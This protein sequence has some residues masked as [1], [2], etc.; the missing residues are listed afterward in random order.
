MESLNNL[1]VQLRD[2][3]EELEKIKSDLLSIYAKYN[4]NNIS[5]TDEELLKAAIQIRKF[6]DKLSNMVVYE[7]NIPRRLNNLELFVAMYDFVADRIYVDQDTSHDIIGTLITNKGVCQGYCQLMSFLC[8][9]FNIPYLY[10]RTETFDENNN[11]LGS[12]GNFEVIVQGNNGFSHCLHCDPTIDSPKSETDTLGFNS[13]LIQDNDIN[14][15]YHKQ[16]PSGNSISSFYNNFLSKQNFEQ[17]ISLLTQIT[18]VEQIISE[19]TDE[20]IINGHF[21]ILKNNLVELNRFFKLNINFNNLDN[22]QLIDVYRAMYKY[23]N[24][25]ATPF[26]PEEL[27]QAIKN[28]KA[29][30]IM[31]EQHIN[32]DD[33]LVQSEKIFEQRMAKSMEQHEKYWD[34]DGGISLMYMESKK[35]NG[36]TI[37]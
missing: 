6:V 31:Y 24:S 33:A 30:E 14:R 37:K 15:Y 13:L 19:K 16:I 8:E 17:S 28:V 18:P 36:P 4:G 22:S 12:H 35:E 27:T 7:N 5:Y 26:D 21:A 20:E 3:K 32:F 2:A 1:K 34:K 11:P 10:K 9:S 25:I 23:Y 29:A